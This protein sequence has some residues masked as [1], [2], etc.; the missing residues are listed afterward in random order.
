MLYILINDKQ[1]KFHI[2][3][4]RKMCLSYGIIPIVENAKNNF[5]NEKSIQHPCESLLQI[6]AA[7]I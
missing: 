4:A 7:D 5:K 3:D 1:T 2:K 6:L